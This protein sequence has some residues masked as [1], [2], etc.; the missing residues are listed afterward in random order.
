MVLHAVEHAL[1]LDR[2]TRNSTAQLDRDS[3]REESSTGSHGSHKSFAFGRGWRSARSGIFSPR[4]GRADA[5]AAPAAL[6][7][8]GAVVESATAPPV[9]SAFR[10][11]SGSVPG[12]LL[13]ADDLGRVSTLDAGERLRQA[14]LGGDEALVG[15]EATTFSEKVLKV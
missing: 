9:C 10:T 3:R 11:R 4:G 12:Q 7:G 14:S 2:A 6:Q 5:P 8:L 13:S 15:A 1:H